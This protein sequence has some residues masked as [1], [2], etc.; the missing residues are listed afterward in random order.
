MTVP[1]PLGRPAVDSGAASSIS[2]SMP[3]R[4][5]DIKHL[6]R[7]LKYFHRI[8][9]S[10]RRR[11]PSGCSEGTEKRRRPKARDD[12]GRPICPVE[13][14]ARDEASCHIREDVGR[15][16]TIRNDTAPVM[17][18]VISSATPSASGNRTRS[19][20][21]MMGPSISV[22]AKAGSLEQAG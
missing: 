11:T 3:W 1:E 17:R 22:R 5:G 16:K 18:P 6:I 9:R 19:E 8:N 15:K 21:T 12:G 2:L 14:E 10:A 7:K 13:H 20:A 4:P